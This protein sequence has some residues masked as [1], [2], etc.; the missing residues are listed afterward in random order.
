MITKVYGRKARY[1]DEGCQESFRC[2][3][4]HG[5]I[6]PSYSVDG[7]IMSVEEASIEKDFCAYCSAEI[8]RT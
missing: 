2:D 7:K 3:R 1:C 6:Y 4:Q 5:L 8:A